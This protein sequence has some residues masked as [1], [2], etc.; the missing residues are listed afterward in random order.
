MAEEHVAVIAGEDH[1]RVVVQSVLF[2][3]GHESAETLVQ[4][5]HVRIVA[6]DG[7]ALRLSASSGD[8]SL[9]CKSLASAR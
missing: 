6:G 9:R 5:R 1:D 4:C 7:L 2:E 3:R 8:T